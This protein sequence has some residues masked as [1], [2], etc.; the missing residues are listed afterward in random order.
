MQ[1][2][3][4][5]TITMTIYVKSMLVFTILQSIIKANM[6]FYIDCHCYRF[7]FAR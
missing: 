5:K 7:L 6:E 3:E 1:I 4:K 2:F